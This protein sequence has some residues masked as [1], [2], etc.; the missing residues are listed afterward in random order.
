MVMMMTPTTTM[1]MMTTT[2]T[3]IIS[4]TINNYYHN[5]SFKR[6]GRA[7][8][9]SGAPGKCWCSS[10]ACSS[11]RL[12][13]SSSACPWTL[14]S[15][16]SQWSS[17]CLTWYR[18]CTSSYSSSSAPFTRPITFGRPLTIHQPGLSGYCWLGFLA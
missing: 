6:Y 10:F 8:S 18:T 1:M 3:M 12:S 17:S 4:I 14:G 16:R 13:G 15:V 5:Y 11:A 9:P 7:T 2:T